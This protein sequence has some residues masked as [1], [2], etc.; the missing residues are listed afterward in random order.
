MDWLGQ[1]KHLSGAS[2]TPPQLTFTSSTAVSSHI[3]S[4]FACLSKP[5][6]TFQASH[7]HNH[8]SFYPLPLAHCCWLLPLPWITNP[9]LLTFPTAWQYKQ[10]F[11]L[12]LFSSRHKNSFMMAL[13]KKTRNVSMSFQ[14]GICGEGSPTGRLT[15]QAGRIEVLT[16]RAAK[17]LRTVRIL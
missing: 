3:V 4:S 1:G 9:L 17:L 2:S 12:F 13:P 15:Q 16:L 6:S 5:T 7:L 8:H 10:L 14:S 11:L